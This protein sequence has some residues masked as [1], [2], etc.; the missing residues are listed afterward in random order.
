MYERFVFDEERIVIC[1][2]VYISEWKV[3]QVSRIAI[4]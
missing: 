1:E 4:Q 3:T 2:P